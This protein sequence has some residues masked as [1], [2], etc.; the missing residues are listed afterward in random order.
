M[1]VAGKPIGA[2]QLNCTKS[3][4]FHGGSETSETGALTDDPTRQTDGLRVGSDESNCA[5]PRSVAAH[6][7]RL[8][9]RDTAAAAHSH[10]AADGAFARW[11]TGLARWRPARGNQCQ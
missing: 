2:V 4:L 3:V 9:R 5:E 10:Q 7:A 6:S 8:G 11:V 1:S